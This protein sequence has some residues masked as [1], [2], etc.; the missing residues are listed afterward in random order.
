MEILLL[1]GIYLVEL[2]CFWLGLRVLFEVQYKTKAVMIFGLVLPIV[3]AV[4]PD[5]DVL[6]KS[7]L[8]AVS[9][10]GVII[11]SI[12]GTVLEK[13]IKLILI[14]LLLECIDGIFLPFC[15]VI[16]KSVDIDYVSY[17]NCFV[18][19]SCTVVFAFL[20]V[21]IKKKIDLKKTHL[22]SIIYLIIAV[23]I[24]LMM[25]C[26]AFL[27]QIVVDLYEKRAIIFSNI[28][29][30]AIYIS[31][32]LLVVFVIYIK[33]THEQMEQLL[34]TEQ[35]LKES[36]VSYYKQVLKKENDTRKYRHDMVNHLIYVQDILSRNRIDDAQQYLANIM[37]GFRK[38]QNI[39]YMTGNEMV[40][41]IM[42][43]YCGLLPENVSIEIKSR[44]PVKIDLE[45]TDICTIFSNLFQNAVE[46]IIEH[47]IK[48]A[49]VIV[50]VQ[51]GKQY[52]EYNIKNSMITEISE[53]YINKN[54]LPK[55]HKSDKSNHGIGMVNVKS[56]IERNHGKFEWY[57]MKG[58]FGVNII[59]PIRYE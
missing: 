59:L 35:L 4:L 13:G 11:V 37:G 22:N 20:V 28:L 3:V 26:L 51:K 2:A 48:G 23:I 50:E 40:D 32:F 19:K 33:S 21:T 5:E 57:Q 25:F 34:K 1:C 39:Y 9:V 55:S 52:V 46:E 56:T 24:S 44:C 53:K 58:Y 38:I 31:I 6:E 47:K 18:A 14:F 43:Y 36:Q 45:D 42:N 27:N 10:L 8:I 16:L 30:V 12:E 7:F 49:K 54:G 17:L 15:E 41:I 29:N